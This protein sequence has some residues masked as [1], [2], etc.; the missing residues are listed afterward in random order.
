MT[1]VYGE[2]IKVDYDSTNATGVSYEIFDELGNFVTNG[3]VGPNGTID[4][5]QLAV[6]NY[7]VYWNNTV[8]L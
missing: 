8:S 6:G 4:V 1:Y 5:D 2:P 3:T 7:T